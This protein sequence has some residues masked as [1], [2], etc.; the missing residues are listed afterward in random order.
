MKGLWLLIVIFGAALYPIVTRADL[1]KQELKNRSNSH[2]SW[3]VE[4]PIAEVFS[5]YKEYSEV[6][7]T[8][9]G[10]LWAKGGKTIADLDGGR[11]EITMRL[12][13]NPFGQGIFFLI[14]LTDQGGSTKVDYWFANSHWRKNGIKLRELMPSA[15]AAP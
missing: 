1:T 9:S 14:E 5:A 3:V 4:S 2:A 7:F 10:F 13:D 15:P 11:A 8:P 6:H 12:Q